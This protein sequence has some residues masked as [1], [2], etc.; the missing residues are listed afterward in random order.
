MYRNYVG[1]ETSSSQNW[2][3]NRRAKSKQDVKKAQCA[4]QAVNN[5]QH[6]PSQLSSS[7][8]DSEVSPAFVSPDYYNMMQQYNAENTMSRSYT[9]STKSH[10]SEDA[11]SASD[12]AMSSAQPDDSFQNFNFNQTSNNLFDSPQDLNRRTLTQEQFNTMQQN[13]LRGSGI[14]GF[15]L[16]METDGY[17]KAFPAYSQQDTK[18]Q[19]VYDFANLPGTSIS[20]KQ[21][22]LPHTVANQS[23]FDFVSTGAM[24]DHSVASSVSSDWGG[25]RSSSISTYNPDT[26]IAQPVTAPQPPPP[27]AQSTTSQWRPGQSVPVDFNQLSQEFRQIEQSRQPQQQ[28]SSEQPLAWPVD[29]AFHERQSSQTASITQSMS[30]VGLKTPQ[31]P[32]HAAFKSPTPATSLAT[33]RQR[34]KP[35]PLGLASMRSQSYSSSSQ[36]ESPAPLSQHQQQQLH[37]NL[38]P[39]QPLRRIKSS[40]MING[41]AQGR[42][43]KTA[44]GSAQRSPMNRTFA[45]AMGSPK[46]IRSISS[47]VGS[48]LAPP[49][50]MSPREQ[51]RVEAARQLQQWQF[52]SGQ[53]SRQASI[54][55]HD[56]EQYMPN[57]STVSGAPANVSSPPH[58]P[59][60]PPQPQFSQQRVGKN[61]ITEN[62]PPQSAPATQLSF[63]SGSFMPPPQPTATQSAHHQPTATNQAQMSQQVMQNVF[64]ANPPHMMAPEPQFPMVDMNMSQQPQFTLTASEPMSMPQMNFS[65]SD[66]SMVDA[67]G[68]LRMTMPQPQYQLASHAQFAPSVSAPLSSQPSP[69]HYPF[70]TTDGVSAGVQISAHAPKVPA[71]PELLV[72]EYQ[73]P[74]DVKR[75]ATPR[76]VPVDSGPKNYTFANQTPEHFEKGKKSSAA[77]AANHSPSSGS[78]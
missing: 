37:T 58:T 69:L 17:N 25:S 36:P 48:N 66:V 34:T 13:G 26:Q 62:T 74:A 46:G 33:R 52:S 10:H 8:S 72:H 7:G 39:S 63:N 1:A 9:G 59:L 28:Y 32:Q 51:A 77:P 49:T 65:L 19:A 35:A 16:E 55:E 22:S 3:Q 40:N 23:A 38:G 53:A 15:D 12:I 67:S 43:Q 45:D 54:S 24:Q 47:Q 75:A 20:A 6:N 29:E 73:P 42:I 5:S 14:P 30:N 68:N 57:V 11:P 56:I 70:P 44:P 41:V 61:I 50:P 31:P 78:S 2:F 60:Y 64:V 18:S 4:I 27:Q 76:K 21:A 71:Q